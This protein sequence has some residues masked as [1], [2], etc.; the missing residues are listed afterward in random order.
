MKVTKVAPGEEGI[1]D[2]VPTLLAPPPNMP[3][4]PDILRYNAGGQKP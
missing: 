2:P 3:P 4:T 1:T